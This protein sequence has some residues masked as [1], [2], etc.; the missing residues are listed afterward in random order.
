MVTCIPWTTVVRTE[1]VLGPG[2]RIVNEDQGLQCTAGFIVKTPDGR[3]FVT[4]AGHCGNPGDHFA[5]DAAVA[6]QGAES[7]VDD[8]GEPAVRSNRDLVGFGVMSESFSAVNPE[9]SKTVT[10]IDIGLIEVDQSLGIPIT[11][12]PTVDV[13][14]A[15]WLPAREL[16]AA[17][18]T[19]TAPVTVCQLGFRTGMTCGTFIRSLRGGQFEYAGLA[20]VGDSGGPVF[21]Q[22]DGAWWGIGV[23]SGVAADTPDGEEMPLVGFELAP[24]M[25]AY[26]LALFG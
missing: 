9:D 26:Q 24:L 5:Y 6:V 7:E 10:G 2:V 13:P 25:E 19:D 11:S 4:V 23:V 15:G 22:V 16:R 8:S 18:Y 14:L 17:A 1:A 12:Q 20:Q 21:A 3:T